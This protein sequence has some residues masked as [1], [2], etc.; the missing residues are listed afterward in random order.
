LPP[1]RSRHGRDRGT[2]HRSAG[3]RPGEGPSRRRGPERRR[4]L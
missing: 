1:S 2:R 3:F 4:R